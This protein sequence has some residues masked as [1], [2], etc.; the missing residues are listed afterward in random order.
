MFV[1]LVCFLYGLYCLSLISL[2]M[3]YNLKLIYRQVAMLSYEKGVIKTHQT[4]N[5]GSESN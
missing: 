2:F 1:F 5:P 4:T 3:I